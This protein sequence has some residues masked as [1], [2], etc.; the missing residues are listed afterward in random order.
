MT[1]KASSSSKGSQATRKRTM[2]CAEARQL[3]VII[4][5]VRITRIL[6]KHA[7]MNFERLSGMCFFSHELGDKNLA[8]RVLLARRLGSRR[9]HCAEV[10][11]TI[12]CIRN[13]FKIGGLC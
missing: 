4:W 2:A 6:L 5:L 11:S 7:F 3:I 9:E 12:I 10:Q 13:F 1:V 8:I